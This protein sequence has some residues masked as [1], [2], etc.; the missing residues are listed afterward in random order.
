VAIP[1]LDVR[2]R[3]LTSGERSYADRIFRGSLDYDPIVITRGS[4]MSAGSARATGNAVNLAEDDFEGATMQ[5]STGGYGT[6]IHELTHVFQY[7]QGGLG[8]MPE[9]LWAQFKAW[10]TTGD[11]NAAYEW[12]P[13][14]A[15]G[16]PW[17][18][19]NVEQQA[20]A[21][22]DYNIH[23][24]RM[25]ANQSYDAVV[26]ARLQ[27]YVEHMRSGPRRAAGGPRPT[28]TARTTP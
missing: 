21:V 12:R 4:I 24:S 16:V 9:S 11:R 26:L 17:E 19:W 8:Y 3:P 22:E 13:L 2:S 28:S 20:A 1:G 5:L 23:L 25:E 6:L 14:A 15:A 27:P 18:Q 10:V 7:Q